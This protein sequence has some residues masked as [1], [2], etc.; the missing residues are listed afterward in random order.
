MYVH[1]NSLVH[2]SVCAQVNMQRWKSNCQEW[3]SSSH[4]VW[5]SSSCPQM[6]WGVFACWTI[7]SPDTYIFKEK[8]FSHLKHQEIWISTV[9]S[10][11]IK[12]CNHLIK[13]LW[14]ARFLM[15]RFCSD[16]AKQSCKACGILKEYLPMS[17]KIIIVYE[18]EKQQNLQL[19]W[20]R[21]CSNR[22]I[23][24]FPKYDNCHWSFWGVA[25]NLKASWIP[26]TYFASVNKT[27][28]VVLVH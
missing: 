11:S 2:G 14:C 7:L 25:Y 9:Y 19:C 1:V 4:V 24:I 20:K 5:G 23:D 6:Q 15:W 26:L 21:N 27:K 10:F 3:V 17:T 22:E 18:K 12:K 16:T 8:L 13:C 28:Y